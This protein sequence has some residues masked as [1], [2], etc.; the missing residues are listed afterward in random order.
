M[1]KIGSLSFKDGNII[2]IY[3]NDKVKW[4]P[5]RIYSITY[6]RDIDGKIFKTKKKLVEKY[7]DLSSC[8]EW[9]NR[10]AWVHNEERR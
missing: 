5:Y 4:N 6:A 10:Y 8:T 2:G 1:K 3:Y 9:L 7:G